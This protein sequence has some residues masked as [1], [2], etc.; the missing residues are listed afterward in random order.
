MKPAITC[1]ST[2]PSAAASSAQRKA[3]AKSGSV[4]SWRNKS[5]VGAAFAMPRHGQPRQIAA[6]VLVAL[7]RGAAEPACRL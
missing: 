7:F 4:L 1:A 6:R 2:S 3:V 5:G